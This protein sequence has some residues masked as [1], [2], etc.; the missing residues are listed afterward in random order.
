[1]ALRRVSL[2]AAQL[3]WVV[4]KVLIYMIIFVVCG[5]CAVAK[6]DLERP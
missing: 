5:L 4:G 2:M 1:V 3:L 6:D